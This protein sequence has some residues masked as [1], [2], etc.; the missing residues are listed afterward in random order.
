MCTWRAWEEPD[1]MA[2]SFTTSAVNSDE[3]PL[4]KCFHKPGAEN[5]QL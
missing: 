2:L 3:H 1:G 4:M 5:V